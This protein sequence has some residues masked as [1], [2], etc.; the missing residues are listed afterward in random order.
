[1]LFSSAESKIVKLIRVDWYLP[2]SKKKKKKKWGKWRGTAK[3]YKPLI[4]RQTNS[5]DLKW[6]MKTRVKNTLLC[7]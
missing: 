3:E 6:S 4:L 1:M 7:T 5:V 2:R